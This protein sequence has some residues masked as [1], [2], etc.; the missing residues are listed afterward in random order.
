M[1]IIKKLYSRRIDVFNGAMA[2]AF[3]TN[4]LRTAI[5]KRGNGEGRRNT[6]QQRR[7]G[8]Y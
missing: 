7:N 6:A 3:N 1:K 8:V 2:K 5:I 4:T